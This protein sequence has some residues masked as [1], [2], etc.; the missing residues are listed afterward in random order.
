MTGVDDSAH[1]LRMLIRNPAEREECGVCAVPS[2]QVEDDVGVAC[3][4]RR[5][6]VPR[7][8][9]DDTLECV[10]LEIVFYVDRED[11]FSCHVSSRRSRG[12]CHAVSFSRE[13]FE[14]FGDSIFDRHARSP[15]QNLFGL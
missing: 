6:S 11:V 2:E 15:V 13:P 5:I 3:D 7:R 1:D 4:A 12:A 14:R 9:V 8:A 10:N